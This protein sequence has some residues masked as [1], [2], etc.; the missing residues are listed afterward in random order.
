MTDTKISVFGAKVG[1][2][3]PDALKAAMTQS[4]ALGGRQEGSFINFS[5]KRGVYEIGIEKRD[6]DNDECWLVN[7]ASFEDGYICWKGGAPQATRLYPM[8]SAIPAL[9]RTEHGPF[10][11]DG[12]GWFDAKAMVIKSLDNDEQGYFKINS[13]S[14]VSS[15]ADLQR[16]ITAKMVSDEAYWPVVNLRREQFTAKGFKNSKPIFHVVGWLSDEA[17]E[18]LAD[19]DD[20]HSLKELFAMSGDTPILPIEGKVAKGRRAL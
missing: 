8:G 13:V 5:G 16:E 17:V 12:D 20:T 4:A 6:T 2:M 19:E 18:M 1:M 15:V 11:K 10:V 3:N 7:V 9:D 14:G